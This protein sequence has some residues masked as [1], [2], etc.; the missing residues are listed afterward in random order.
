MRYKKIITQ[1]VQSIEPKGMEAY[2]LNDFRN[3]VF[4]SNNEH[5]VK[6]ENSCRILCM[7]ECNNIY[8]GNTNIL[9]SYIQHWKTLM[10]N[11]L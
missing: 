10:Y 6:V 7:M 2:M 5:I 3:Y 4:L 1:T 9:R 8:V 11:I